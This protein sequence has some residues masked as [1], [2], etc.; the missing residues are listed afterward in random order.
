MLSFKDFL[1]EDDDRYLRT[2]LKHK[3]KIYKGH[4]GEGHIDLA[5]RHSIPDNESNRGFVNHKGHFLNRNK[6]LPYARTNGLFMYG[7]NQSDYGDNAGVASEF[8]KARKF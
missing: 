8:L 1:R 4:Q 7:H 2:A 6:A 5:A 3:D